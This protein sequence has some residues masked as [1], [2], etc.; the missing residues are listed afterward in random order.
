MSKLY[1]W[2]VNNYIKLHTLW[3]QLE[4]NF[5]IILIQTYSINTKAHKLMPYSVFIQAL[6]NKWIQ[7][8][9]LRSRKNGKLGLRNTFQIS[10]IHN[11]PKV[12]LSKTRV[13]SLE[14]FLSLNIIRDGQDLTSAP[15]KMSQYTF[16]I[17]IHCACM[18]QFNNDKVKQTQRH[19]CDVRVFVGY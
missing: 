11:S 16:S 7:E 2:F 15:F 13:N 19:S 10:E 14:V 12:E 8:S 18:S 6:L 3:W 9:A 17:H 4:G 5:G 1:L